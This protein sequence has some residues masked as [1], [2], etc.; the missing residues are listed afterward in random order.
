MNGNHSVNFESG[1]AFRQALSDFRSCMDRQDWSGA[2]EK[3]SLASQIP[4]YEEDP[5][6]TDMYEELAEKAVPSSDL[7]AVAVAS[8]FPAIVTVFVPVPVT[9][10][11]AADAEPPYSPMVASAMASPC[12]SI[13]TEPS[14]VSLSFLSAQII[15]QSSGM[16]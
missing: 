6:I 5:R 11:A 9:L 2:A 8:A 4:G 1:E 16:V 12:V 13:R 15:R 3:A 14:A 7:S 10:I